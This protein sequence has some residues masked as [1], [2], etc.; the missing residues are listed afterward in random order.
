MMVQKGEISELLKDSDE[1]GFRAIW[2]Q[3]RFDTRGRRSKEYLTNY[4]HNASNTM[5]HAPVNT[6]YDTNSRRHS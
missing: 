1:C 3:C 4:Q 5:S 6:V 2:L